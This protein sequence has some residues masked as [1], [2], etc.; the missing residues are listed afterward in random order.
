MFARRA[1]VCV[2]TIGAFLVVAAGCSGSDDPPPKTT[3]S[4]S[5]FIGKPLGDAYRAV[6]YAPP[7]KISPDAGVTTY[8]VAPLLTSTPPGGQ[9]QADWTVVAS[10]FTA[11]PVPGGP[12]TPAPRLILGAAPADLA[13]A[14]VVT[15][16]RDG[17]YRGKLTEC[18][19]QTD[20]TFAVTTG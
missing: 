17:A 5:S 16:A 7:T 3:L 13:T 4:A 2:T 11:A 20:D 10:C 12:G 19:G 1:V 9:A 6:G 15:N 18:H 8:N 14:A